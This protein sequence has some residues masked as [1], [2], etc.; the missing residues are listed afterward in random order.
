MTTFHLIRHGQTIWHEENRYAGSSDIELTPAG[1]AQARSLEPWAK[2][3]NI[4]LV[5]SSPLQRAVKTAQYVATAAEAPLELDPQF[6][7]VDF[8]RAEGLTQAQ[9]ARHFPDELASFLVTPA[10]TPLP[11]GELGADALQRALTGLIKLAHRHPDRVVAIVTHTTLI[12]LLLCGALNLPLNDYRR[13][14]PQID[15]ATI[16]TLSLIDTNLTAASIHR[17][18]SRR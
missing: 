14:F 5:I 16:T 8:G 10:T 7:E 4:D 2:S 1:H 6:R 9:M 12:R 18:N 3:G 17:V 15:N 13:R 11:D